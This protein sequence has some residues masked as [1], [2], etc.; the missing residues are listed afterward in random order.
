M[1]EV[2]EEAM[3]QSGGEKIDNVRSEVSQQ[4]DI[5]QHEGLARYTRDSQNEIN[6]LFPILSNP[7]LT[8]YVYPHLAGDEQLPVPGYTTGFT[9]YEKNHY[10]MLG[11]KS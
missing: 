1:A 4:V 10:A 2:Y 9:L 5:S 11:E 7:M 3:Q 8:M 6:N